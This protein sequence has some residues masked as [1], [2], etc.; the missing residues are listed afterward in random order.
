[1]TFLGTQKKS[2]IYKQIATVKNKRLE[3]IQSYVFHMRATQMCSP[4]TLM[5]L[6]SGKLKSSPHQ[7]F[8]KIW[9]KELSLRNVV[10]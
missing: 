1:M 5:T 7:V 10:V 9:A 2:I 3:G 4:A 8:I 6:E